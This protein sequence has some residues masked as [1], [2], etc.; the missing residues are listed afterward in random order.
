MAPGA[1]NFPIN[2]NLL[3]HDSCYLWYVKPLYLFLSLYFAILVAYP[4]TDA[5]ERAHEGTALHIQQAQPGMDQCSPFCICACCAT[6][7]QL[8]TD[9]ILLTVATHHHSKF[10]TPYLDRP[11]LHRQTPVWQ[12]PRHS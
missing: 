11:L 3:H 7:V 10:I 8:T 9:A 2:E 4:C 5:D 1:A 6:S 12:P